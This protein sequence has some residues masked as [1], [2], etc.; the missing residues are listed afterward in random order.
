[1]IFVNYTKYLIFKAFLQVSY[2]IFTVNHIFVI[3]IFNWFYNIVDITPISNIF[4]VLVQLVEL[5]SYQSSSSF[6]LRIYF[7]SWMIQYIQ[8]WDRYLIV[9]FEK[10]SVCQ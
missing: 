9:I 4:A 5:Y 6:W 10:R 3:N 2:V 7:I 1:M 8:Y